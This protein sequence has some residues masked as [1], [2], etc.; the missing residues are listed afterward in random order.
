MDDLLLDVLTCYISST[1]PSPTCIPTVPTVFCTC[2]LHVETG[3]MI[4]M[5]MCQIR[6]AQWVSMKDM[7]LCCYIK[8]YDAYVPS[9]TFQL[10]W[11]RCRIYLISRKIRKQCLIRFWDGNAAADEK[12]RTRN[13][14]CLQKQQQ[15][16][17]SF[18]TTNQFQNN[19]N[20]LI[21]KQQQQIS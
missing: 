5:R 14:A 8:W 4:V 9:S 12:L 13:Q 17:I 16:Q 2:T 18:K 11:Q 20:K 7:V 1:T 21:A 6:C 3:E 15:Q 10:I 19:N